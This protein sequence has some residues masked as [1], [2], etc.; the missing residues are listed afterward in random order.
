MASNTNQHAIP[1]SMAR[2]L[3]TRVKLYRKY[4]ANA[5]APGIINENKPLIKE[6][7]FEFIDCKIEKGRSLILI[8]PTQQTTKHWL[9]MPNNKFGMI[10]MPTMPKAII[11]VKPT[12][13]IK[14]FTNTDLTGFASRKVKNCTTGS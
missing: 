9:Q 1:E 13:G 11:E 8:Y 3:I 5:N 14:Y 6:P 12:I 4:C 10:L 7:D 2:I